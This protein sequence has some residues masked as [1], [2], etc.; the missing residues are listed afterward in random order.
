MC[1]NLMEEKEKYSEKK[2]VPAESRKSLEIIM[3]VLL[4][5]SLSSFLLIV[6]EKVPK[7]HAFLIDSIFIILVYIAVIYSLTFYKLEKNHF[8][9]PRTVLVVLFSLF[10]YI[11][12]RTYININGIDKLGSTGL[13]V[14]LIILFFSGV[15]WGFWEST[16]K[17]KKFEIKKV[18]VDARF[19]VSIAL[20]FMFVINLING[21][22]F[23]P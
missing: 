16:S 13:S 20:T 15:V 5:V 7:I 8:L 4:G 10:P 6:I 3:G 21:G 18:F 14:Y 19:W 11:L 1:I 12:S 17:G 23:L 22:K 2:E 9:I